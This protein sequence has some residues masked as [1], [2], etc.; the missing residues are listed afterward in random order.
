MPR[1]PG[2]RRWLAS[3]ILVLRET[4]FDDGSGRRVAARLTP[5]L[6]DLTTPLP[7]RTLVSAVADLLRELDVR[8]EEDAGCARWREETGRAYIAFWQARLRRERAIQETLLGGRAA[9]FQP[10]LFD[11]RA[12]QTRLAS[13]EDNRRLATE[14]ARYV[15]AAERAVADAST[16]TRTAVVLVP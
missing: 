11:R 3:R 8:M 13:L 14:S 9:L 12:E 1:R 2:T 6:V 5:V 10:G 4:I 15:A 16:S 7:R